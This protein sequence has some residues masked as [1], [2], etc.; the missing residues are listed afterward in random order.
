MQTRQRI[1]NDEIISG[2][3]ELGVLL[4][5]HDYTG[6][7]TGSLLS[8]DEARAILPGQSATTLQ[9]GG[10]HHRCRAAG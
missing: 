4:L 9:V 7:W 5:G 6:W 10:Q 3:D 8:I 1:L 2:R